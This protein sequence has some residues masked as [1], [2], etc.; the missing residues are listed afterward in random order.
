MMTYCSRAPPPL[1]P[2]IQLDLA[3]VFGHVKEDADALFIDSIIEKDPTSDFRMRVTHDTSGGGKRAQTRM[4]VLE[5]GYL[6]LRGPHLNAPVTKLRM[7]PITGRR[8]QLR[9]ATG[10]T[11]RVA[12]T[13]R[14]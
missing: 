3:L 4:E 1:P 7:K 14:Q 2:P 5:R 8:H 6:T 13:Q 10:Q 12:S 9:C 11:G